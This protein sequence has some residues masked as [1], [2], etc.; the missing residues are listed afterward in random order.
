MSAIN[1]KNNVSCL[2]KGWEITQLSDICERITKGSTP[3]SYGFAYTTSGIKFVKAENIDDKGFAS[4]TTNFI[5]EKTNK[6]LSRSILKENDLLF[7]IAGTIGRVGM[8]RRIDLP[9][10]TN[11][12]LAIIRH[13]PDLVDTKYLFYYLKSDAIQKEAIKRIVGVGRANLSL[14][15]ISDFKILLAPL[16]LQKKIVEEIETQFTRLD[17]GV[18]ALKRAQANLKRYR[19]AVL[20]AACEGKGYPKVKLT[21]IVDINPRSFIKSITDSEYLSFVPMKIVQEETGIIGSA[22][23]EKWKDVKKGYTP[24]QNGDV[25]FAKITPCMENGKIALAENLYKG[26]AAGST[27]FHVFRPKSVLN[28]KYLLF[29][30]LDP[31]LREDAKLVMQGAAGQLRVPVSF[32]KNLKIALPTLGEQNLIVG[33]MERRFSVIDKQ[34]ENITEKIKMAGNLRNAI[35]TNS[36]KI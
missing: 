15:E 32:F 11:Q 14:K 31:S 9:S 12:A 6:Y 36:F 33:E 18:A 1:I 10:N 2:P 23:K 13:K 24:F 3:T 20:K 34:E 22:L 27:E 16:D 5:D 25:I 26:R 21:D 4:T 30:L 19:A 8:V 29:Y 35:L 28:S 17:A 7:S